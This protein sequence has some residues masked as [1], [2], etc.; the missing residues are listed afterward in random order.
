MEIKKDKDLHTSQ[1]RESKV[2]FAKS[3]HLAQSIY[4]IVVRLGLTDLMMMDDVAY[5]EFCQRFHDY[6]HRDRFP[7]FTNRDW[8]DIHKE[9]E[10]I[11]EL[12]GKL[13]QLG[14]YKGYPMAKFMTQ[15]ETFQE[16]MTSGQYH[17]K[18]LHKQD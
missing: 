6:A 7:K 8:R 11:A 16:R 12:M 2:S 13:T 3:S 18:R 17:L 14:F 9:K 10:C 5:H 4:S 15:M 1:L